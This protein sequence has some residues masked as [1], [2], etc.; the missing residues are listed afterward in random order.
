MELY[1]DLVPATLCGGGAGS[2]VGGGAE[3]D[4]MASSLSQAS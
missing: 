2:T 3:E 4:P 1:N